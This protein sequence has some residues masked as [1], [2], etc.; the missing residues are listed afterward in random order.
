MEPLISISEQPEEGEATTSTPLSVWYH[1][2]TAAALLVDSCNP[3][4]ASSEP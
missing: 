4:T 1:N 2:F 3:T